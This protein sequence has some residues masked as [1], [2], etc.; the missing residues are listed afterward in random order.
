MNTA[1]IPLNAA[2]LFWDVFVKPVIDLPNKESIVLI[3][4]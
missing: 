3:Q 4:Q 2:P 1:P